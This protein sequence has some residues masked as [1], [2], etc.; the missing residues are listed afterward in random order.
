MAKR[1]STAKVCGNNPSVIEPT[2][3]IAAVDQDDYT[4]RMTGA[5]VVWRGAGDCV[6][7]A[8]MLTEEDDNESSD[9]EWDYWKTHFVGAGLFLGPGGDIFAEESIV[10]AQRW[11]DRLAE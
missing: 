10:D 8:E 6:E 9:F 3:A 1:P 7:D 2:P 11:I 4:D 5:Q